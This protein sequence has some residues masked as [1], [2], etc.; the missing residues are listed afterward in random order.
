M[1]ADFGAS[2]DL[3]ISIPCTVFYATVAYNARA[4]WASEHVEDYLR[5]L[6]G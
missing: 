4:P 2:Q 3:V 1:L 5:P 6:G